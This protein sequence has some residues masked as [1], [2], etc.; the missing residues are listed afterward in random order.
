MPACQHYC[1][2]SA[3][4]APTCCCQR[5]ICGQLC[6][7]QH[8][9]TTHCRCV[10]TRHKGAHLHKVA[11]CMWQRCQHSPQHS[12]HAHLAAKL[13]LAPGSSQVRHSTHHWAPSLPLTAVCS[14]SS[15]CTPA[16]HWLQQLTFAPPCH[17]L[18]MYAGTY[19]GD[20]SKPPLPSAAAVLLLA[21]PLLPM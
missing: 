7:I 16:S 18:K 13:S 9:H 10:D 8:L 3:V 2:T 15:S 5:R 20:R 21:A 17:Q 11:W 12:T 4:P 1:G 19:T 14:T 6:V